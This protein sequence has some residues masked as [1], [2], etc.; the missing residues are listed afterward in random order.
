MEQT[1]D[2]KQILNIVKRRRHWLFWPFLCIVLLT[3]TV[4]LVLPNTYLSTATI[5]IQNQQIP[6]TMVP[7]TVTTYAEERI[8][9]ITQEV[10]GRTKILSLVSKFDLLP[11][12]RQKLTTDDL[13]E[14]IRKRISIQPVNAEINKEAKGKP[15]ILTIAF[16]LSYQ[17]E[18]PRKAQA[19]ANE[20]ASYYMEK[21]PGVP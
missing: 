12:K 8:Q 9:T 5:L 7:T 21:E 18:D 2:L 3:T 16:T 11:T 10:T 17:D 13:V 6:N 4:A 14:R 19:V 15:S 20:I 1:P